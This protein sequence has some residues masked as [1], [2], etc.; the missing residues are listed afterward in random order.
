MQQKPCP[1]CGGPVN[2][3]A[4]RCPRCNK[5]LLAPCSGNCGSCRKG[6]CH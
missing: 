2:A 1:Q 5:L 6:A 4:A 3:Q